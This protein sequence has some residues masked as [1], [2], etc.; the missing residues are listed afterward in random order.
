MP[1]WHL[2]DKE[3]QDICFVYHHVWAPITN[4]SSWILCTEKGLYLYALFFLILKL[5]KNYNSKTNSEVEKFWLIWTGRVSYWSERVASCNKYLLNTVSW[6]FYSWNAF[7]ISPGA[8]GILN[9]AVSVCSLNQWW[10][11]WNLSSCFSW[12]RSCL[13]SLC[14]TY[15][16]CWSTSLVVS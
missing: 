13:S 12:D 11:S 4:L 6:S 16:F 14:F 9:P 10:F 1:F 15:L 2:L 7:S 3:T 8:S 5:Y